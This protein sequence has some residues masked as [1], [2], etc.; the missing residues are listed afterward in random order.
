MVAR[1]E[2][3]IHLRSAELEGPFTAAA[4]IFYLEEPEEPS[5]DPQKELKARLKRWWIKEITFQ[6]PASSE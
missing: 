6:P 5:D 4:R 3:T 1:M 2:F